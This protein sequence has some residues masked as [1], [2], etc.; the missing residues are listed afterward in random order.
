MFSNIVPQQFL[1]EHSAMLFGQPLAEH[2]DRIDIGQV[3]KQA[4]LLRLVLQDWQ[5]VRV[6]GPKLL[7]ARRV[8]NGDGYRLGQVRCRQS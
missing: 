8:P 6:L 4:I 3:R 1:C 5:F 7:S 2:Q